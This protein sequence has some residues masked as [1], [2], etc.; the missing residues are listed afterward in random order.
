MHCRLIITCL[1]ILNCFIAWGQQTFIQNYPIEVYQGTTQNWAIRQDG[2]G[3][4]YVAN[5]EGVIRYDG[6]RWNL[7]SLPGKEA[8]HAID[9]DQ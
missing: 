8:V 2:Q 5:S 7:I 9:I 3:V 6:V 1:F 4:I